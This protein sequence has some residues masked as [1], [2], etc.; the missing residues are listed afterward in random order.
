LRA[1]DGLIIA[2]QAE[3]LRLRARYAVSPVKV[4]PIFNPIDTA[5]WHALARASA[6]AQLG[7]PEGASVVVWHGRVEH[8]K[9]LDILLH[10]WARISRERPDRDL[11]LLIVGTGSDAEALRDRIA[12][13]QLRTVRWV[14]RFVGDQNEIRHYLSA[15][16]VY[17]FPSREEGFAVAPLEATE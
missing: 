12:A 3:A 17:A 13:M 6:R 5:S 10:A 1:C 2:A 14:D 4:G 11:R 15:A 7:I 8:W 9:G 16:D